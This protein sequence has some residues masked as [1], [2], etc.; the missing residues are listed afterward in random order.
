MYTKYFGLTEEPF[1]IA[2]NP[3]FLYMSTRHREALAH[4]LYGIRNDSG[5]VLLTGEVGTG[6][7]TVCRC[8]LQQLPENTDVAFILN[9]K[10][11]VL[12]L[13]DSI[14]DE[15]GIDGQR[16]PDSVKSCVDAINHSLLDRHAAG[17]NTVVIIDEA[18]N[19]SI[20]VLEQLRLL[21][22]LETDEGK[23]L[24]IILLGQPELEQML[25]R[26]ELRQVDQRITAR[27]RLQSLL[28]SEI[29]AYVS[30]RL[31]VAGCREPV[32]SPSILAKLYRKTD[33][34]PRLINIICDRAML[35]AYAKSKRRIN[36]PILVKAAQ[37]V[38]GRA[39]HSAWRAGG[40]IATLVLLAGV[41][42]LAA[43]YYI[44]GHD[45]D[46]LIA[47][48]WAAPE[49]TGEVVA[50]VIPK[51]TVQAETV[52]TEAILPEP[53]DLPVTE[54]VTAP[55]EPSWPVRARAGEGTLAAAYATL[56]RQWNLAPAADDANPCKLARASRLYCFSGAGNLGSLSAYDRPAILTLF[57][58][59]GSR[60]H[61]ILLG[62]R[63][64]QVTLAFAHGVE[65]VM[66]KDLEARWR[67]QFLLLWR[68]SPFGSTLIVPGSRGRNIAWLTQ[69]LIDAG[70]TPLQV[71]EVYDDAVVTAVRAFQRTHGLVTDGIVGRQTLIRLNSVNDKSIPRLAARETG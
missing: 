60:Y 56:F 67:G 64:D 48:L 34:I 23:L 33:G 47:R 18:Q 53:E 7:T 70:I 26:S 14:C 35:G 63:E 59:D 55:A 71:K 65:T 3:R 49:P 37:E 61:A 66:V 25:A 50:T 58:D 12:E 69:T 17:R 24:R 19:L 15:L 32:F 43:L 8:L 21:T 20:D 42:T 57:D 45:V 41:T 1:S 36:R 27:Y 39:K 11:S 31:A 68:G 2:A 9:P 29:G 5:I 28:R 40:A 62:L 52:V 4:L 44:N 6:K 38:Q 10:V 54:P 22:N 51:T 46:A 13:L 30:H 16:N